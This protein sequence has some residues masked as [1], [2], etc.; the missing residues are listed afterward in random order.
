MNLIA[1]LG[2][3]NL[4]LGKQ[5]S[6]LQ[7]SSFLIKLWKVELKNKKLDRPSEND[8]E[9]NV[10]YQYDFEDIKYIQNSMFFK[11]KLKFQENNSKWLKSGNKVFATAAATW[12]HVRSDS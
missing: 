11:Y 8:N 5:R 10:Y 3:W 4:L 2:N 12:K 1:E 7:F 9:N 6:R